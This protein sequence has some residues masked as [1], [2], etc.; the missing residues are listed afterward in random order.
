MFKENS[1]QC[2][3]PPHRVPKTHVASQGQKSS[4]FGGSLATHMPAT[5]FAF[6]IQNIHTYKPRKYACI[7]TETWTPSKS[8][9][10]PAPL[11]QFPGY[12]GAHASEWWENVER[13]AP[14]GGGFWLPTFAGPVCLAD[15]CMA[16]ACTHTHTHA[17]AFLIQGFAGKK[18]NE[19]E[20]ENVRTS[21]SR[22][23]IRSS[24]S[25]LADFFFFFFSFFLKSS[26]IMKWEFRIQA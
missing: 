22:E 9:A 3:T 15:P 24:L 13:R 19:F 16:H 14:A 11:P 23:T 7:P 4:T 8:Q 6:R 25:V 1:L 18:E 17:H 10:N 21:Q 20:P 26:M 2:L 5:R 12:R